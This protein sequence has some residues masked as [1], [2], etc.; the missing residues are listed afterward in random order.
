ML[1]NQS[2]L[3]NK[4]IL[5]T[6]GAGFIGS[7]V[8]EEFIKQGA[9]IKAFDNLHTGYNLIPAE[10]KNHIDFSF[11][12]GDIRSI[13]DLIQSISSIGGVDYIVHLG[14][15]AN[16]PESLKSPLLYNEVNVN[17]SLNVLNVAR[18]LEVK[19]VIIASSSS[20]YGDSSTALQCEFHPTNPMSPYAETKLLVEKISKFYNKYLIVNNLRFFNVIGER[21]LCIGE[22]AVVPTFI[23]KLL[24]NST[25]TI[26]GTGEQRRDFIYVKD[27]VEAI[28]NALILPLRGD[29]YNVGS[30]SSCSINHLYDLLQVQIGTNLQPLPA[31]KR[32]GDV[33]NSCAN[34]LKAQQMLDFYPKYS[35]ESGLK[36][37]VNYYKVNNG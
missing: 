2:P 4:R 7:H 12:L 33:E 8:C 1:I 22:G 24:N 29:I 36:E 3:S 30:G 9:T 32:P 16:V 26:Y 17:G 14:A 28:K 15:L 21:Q 6:G 5:V 35:L 19:K 27:V 20:V 37:T 10:T 23:K 34:I 11:W 18:Q 13:S 25:P 31:P